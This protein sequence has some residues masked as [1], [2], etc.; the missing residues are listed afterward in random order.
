MGNGD[1]IMS[2]KEVLRHEV[3][4]SLDKKVLKQAAAAKKLGISIRQVKRLY[5]KY[6][7][8]GVS[9]LIS[10]RRGQRSNNRI[11][12][13]VKKQALSLV[14]DNYADFGPT[15]AMEKLSQNHSIKVSKETLRKWMLDGGIWFGKKRKRLVVHQLRERRRV[16]RQL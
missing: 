5:G 12:E 13:E 7:S 16:E 4:I 11:S 1:I 14:S 15:L 9:G 6:K 10:K 8:Q 2:Q 3:I